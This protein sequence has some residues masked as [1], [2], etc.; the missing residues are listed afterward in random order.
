MIKMMG[1]L[2]AGLVLVGCATTKPEMP[3]SIYSEAAKL[4]VGIEYCVRM[5]WLSPDLGAIGKRGIES[6]INE[7]SYDYERLNSE[8]RMINS[9]SQKPNQGDCNK[10]AMDIQGYNQNNTLQNQAARDNQRETQ[11]IINNTRMQN[12]YCNRIGNQTVCSTY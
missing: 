7:Y 11:E 4:H 2:L 3:G 6:R 10:A 8:A 9:D 1:V 12:T 5:G